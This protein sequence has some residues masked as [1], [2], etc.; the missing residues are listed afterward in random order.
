[1]DDDAD[2]DLDD[3]G[4]V[5]KKPPAFF[6]LKSMLTRTRVDK[7]H[8][9]V[10]PWAVL[11]PDHGRRLVWE[12]IALF[13]NFVYAVWVP[14]AA[15]FG[16]TLAAA[17]LSSA[18]FPWSWLYACWAIDAFFV[19]DMYLRLAHFATVDDEG[20][21]V[22]QRGEFA[23]RY[24]A[25]SFRLDFVAILPLELIPLLLADSST[26]GTAVGPR[27]FLFWWRLNRVLRAVRLPAAYAQLRQVPSFWHT[28]LDHVQAFV[29]VPP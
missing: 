25:S 23:R 16:G 13:L 20:A 2:M 1:V 28:S 4:A 14:F 9:E 8:A 27:R 26:A 29:C 17:P 24:L 11:A 6:K 5:D 19:V 18:L 22:N 3:I 15:A 21:P 12:A 10:V 7:L